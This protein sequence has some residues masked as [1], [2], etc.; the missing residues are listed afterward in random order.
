MPFDLDAIIGITG[1]FKDCASPKTSIFILLSAAASIMFKTKMRGSCISISW[2]VMYRL[3]SKFDASIMLTTQSGFS[4]SKNCAL[5]VRLRKNL[6]KRLKN[7]RP[8]NRRL[9]PSFR[10]VRKSGF[11]FHRYARPIPDIL[12]RPRQCVKNCRFSAIG[13]ADQS[14]FPIGCIHV[15]FV[16]TYFLFTAVTVMTAASRRRRE[17][18]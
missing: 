6:P 14:Y 7:T 8:V 13:I 15:F 11:L 4:Y 3:R 17:T 2:S 1:T 18:A 5:P 12:V 9:P 16:R 10:F